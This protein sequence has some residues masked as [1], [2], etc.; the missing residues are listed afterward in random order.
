MQ[1]I[2]KANITEDSLPPPE[3]E[4]LNWVAPNGYDASSEP[5]HAFFPEIKAP[6]TLPFSRASVHWCN[7]EAN[8][9]RTFENPRFFDSLNDLKDELRLN[10]HN[11]SRS[12]AEQALDLGKSFMSGHT[13]V[14]A[15]T[16]SHK[17]IAH[18]IK[19]DLD[20]GLDHHGIKLPSK[21]YV[22]LLEFL[23]YS[24]YLLQ[25]AM[26]QSVIMHGWEQGNAPV[27]FN[28][29]CLNCPG[30]QSLTDLQ[31][32]QFVS[33]LPQLFLE[34]FSTGRLEENSMTAA[35]I[36]EDRSG[37]ARN[38]L[39]ILHRNRATWINCA[40]QINRRLEA[41]AT[42]RQTKEVAAKR[43]FDA[44]NKK[45]EKRADKDWNNWRLEM[46]RDRVNSNTYCICNVAFL[47]ENN[48]EEEWWGCD[49]K[50]K[51]PYRGWLHSNCQPP[52]AVFTSE[53]SETSDHTFWC[54]FCYV[55]VRGFE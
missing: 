47:K 20:T 9:L 50:T 48:V 44:A 52:I 24:P 49:A 3:P 26:A 16:H 38:D 32:E 15:G 45:V 11:A 17:P 6:N 25:Q 54:D 33:K 28:R 22:P 53:S 1:K 42:L 8:Q 2:K 7:G 43:K 27:D 23:N 41:E 13:Q 37:I 36:P 18:S 29:M 30:F 34:A 46:K 14:R 10:K 19:E 55:H 39:D 12:G 35:G 51:C 5:I 4:K 40:G 31:A 21:H